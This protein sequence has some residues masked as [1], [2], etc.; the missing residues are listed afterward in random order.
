MTWMTRVTGITEI[1]N[2]TGVT[3]MTGIATM[4]GMTRLQG[5]TFF[6][7]QKKNSVTFKDTFPVFK[8]SNQSFE[9]ISF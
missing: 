4:T 9:F 3:G 6:L 5:C 7:K 2:M 8:D 1:T